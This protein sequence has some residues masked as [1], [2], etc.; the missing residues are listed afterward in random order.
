M[1]RSNNQRRETMKKKGKAFIPSWSKSKTK[2]MANRSKLV[3]LKHDKKLPYN[4]IIDRKS[5][6]VEKRRFK[7]GGFNNSG[8]F[9]KAKGNAARSGKKSMGRK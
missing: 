3:A 2:R 7:S 8:K 6:Q 1:G 5:G 9:G 4:K